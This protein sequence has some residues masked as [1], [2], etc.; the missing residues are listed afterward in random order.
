MRS[1]NCRQFELLIAP[2]L[3][4][5]VKQW[6][7]GREKTEADEGTVH[8]SA[9]CRKNGGEMQRWCT[10]N[11][12]SMP[13]GARG[14]AKFRGPPEFLFRPLRDPWIRFGNSHVKPGHCLVPIVFRAL[15]S[16][17]IPPARLHRESRLLVWEFFFRWLPKSALLDFFSLH[18]EINF[19]NQ[20]AL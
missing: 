5:A 18:W 9:A 11:N 1:K 7:C 2:R 6:D 17:C 10:P 13:L 20:R 3:P 19:E 8:I 4:T 15:F 12:Q 14:S 16:W